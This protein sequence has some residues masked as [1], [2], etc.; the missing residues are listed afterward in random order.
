MGI[1]DLFKKKNGDTEN[2]ALPREEAGE[3]IAPEAGEDAAGADQPVPAREEAPSG[4]AETEI[5]EEDEEEEPSA[6]V[7]GDAVTAPEDEDIPGVEEAVLRQIQAICADR[8]ARIRVLDHHIAMLE[9]LKEAFPALAMFPPEKPPRPGMSQEEAGIALGQTIANAA[10]AL[11]MVRCR[12]A[13]QHFNDVETDAL[14]DA[15]V[16]LNYYAAAASGSDPA[17]FIRARKM[18]DRTLWGRITKEDLPRLAKTRAV[19]RLREGVDY[20]LQMQEEDWAYMAEIHDRVGV[21]PGMKAPEKGKISFVSFGITKEE[22]EWK[23][24]AKEGDERPRVNQLLNTLL[25]QLPQ[26]RLLA[27][28]VIDT[29]QG[30][31]ITP[32]PLKPGCPTADGRKLVRWRSALGAKRVRD[33]ETVY[34]VVSRATGSRF[35]MLDPNYTAWAFSAREFADAVIR[36]NPAFDL[37]VRSMTQEKFREYVSTF[38]PMGVTAFR[39]NPGTRDH[40][41]EVLTDDYLETSSAPLGYEG[42]ALNR[43]ILRW[44]QNRLTEGD[45]AADA[46]A[47]TAW[48]LIAHV[49]PGTLFLVPF[50]YKEDVFTDDTTLHVTGPSAGLVNLRA[51]ERSLGRR[52]RPGEKPEF[53]KVNG[54]PVLMYDRD[55]FFGGRGYTLA[56]PRQTAVARPMLFSTVKKEEN[57]YMCGFTDLEAF[58]KVFSMHKRVAVLTWDELKRHVGRKNSDGSVSEGLVINPGYT[59]LI[60]DQTQI[61]DLDKARKEPVK[62]FMPAKKDPPAGAAKA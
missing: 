46:M 44:K 38:A 58:A 47:D 5:E 45:P 32:V 42:A 57:T 40:F 41:C 15:W 54:V 1:F 14:K 43:L 48:N 60:L 25:R 16:L 37:R 11:S 59:E 10:K 6:F 34:V 62:I 35:P 22:F 39:W 19:G 31:R 55:M 21:I 4:E 49:L 7:P 20:I 36:G 24:E 56:D 50:N 61:E 33:C 8:A 28:G 3:T 9:S 26:D 51:L 13:L 23:D 12:Q 17:P 52:L 29:T 53:K 2:G 18:L 27:S 30:G